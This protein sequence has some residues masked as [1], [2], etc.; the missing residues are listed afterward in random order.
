MDYIIVNRIT[1]LYLYKNFI[2]QNQ[3]KLIE[4]KLI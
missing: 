2:L 4:F 1:Y 3:K